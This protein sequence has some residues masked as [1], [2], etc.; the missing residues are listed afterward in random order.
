MYY[1]SLIPA[2][3]CFSKVN[4]KNV[5]RGKQSY[6]QIIQTVRDLANPR[7]RV[8]SLPGPEI[9]QSLHS[10]TKAANAK[11]QKQLHRSVAF[12][13]TYDD[14]K[15]QTS[16][17]GNDD[18]SYSP[19]HFPTPPHAFQPPEISQSSQSLCYW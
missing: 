10:S 1:A 12:Q 14:D 7:Y 6:A 11:L 5:N 17:E 13:V 2:S 15:S 19:T 18:K 9:E 3:V 16:V 8:H 4:K